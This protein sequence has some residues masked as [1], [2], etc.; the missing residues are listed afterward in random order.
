MV[1]RESKFHNSSSSLFLVIIKQSASQADIWWSVCISKCLSISHVSFS[2]TDTG[3]CIY[4]LFVWS[5]FNFLHNSQCI[6]FHNQSCV[7]L[8]SFCANLLHS[9]IIWLIVSSRLLNNKHQLFCC[10]LSIDM[11]GSY[12]VIFQRN[13]VSLTRSPVLSHVHIFSCKMSIVRRIK[14]W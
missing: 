14:R 5:S 8:S 4:N 6:H 2:G 13:S 7:V 12:G 3:L 10:V 11:N 9:F 1:S